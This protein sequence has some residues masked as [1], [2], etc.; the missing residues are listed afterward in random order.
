MEMVEMV[1][2][3]I[4]AIWMEVSPTGETLEEFTARVNA[5]FDEADVI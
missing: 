3:D 2:Q 4:V 1:R 5:E